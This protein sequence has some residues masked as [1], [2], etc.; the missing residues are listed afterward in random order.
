MPTYDYECRACGHSFDVFQSMSDEALSV[1]PACQKKQL[2][3][4]IGGGVGVIFKGSGFYINDSRSK[5]SSVASGSNGSNGKD[6]GDSAK[7][8]DKSATATDKSTASGGNGDGSKSGS[9]E[10]ASSKKSAAAAT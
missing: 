3:R 2:R 10:A 6:S 8:G 1:C 5:S 9:T 7:S 4:L